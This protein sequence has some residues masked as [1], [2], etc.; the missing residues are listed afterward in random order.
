MD[1]HGIITK[2]KDEILCVDFVSP[3]P[4]GSW[5]LR[6][7]LVS[8]D[9]FTNV[10]RLYPLARPT[11]RAAL[12]AIVNKYIPE[13]RATKRVIID[14]GKQFRM[15]YGLPF[16]VTILPNHSLRSFGGP[17]EIWQKVSTRNCDDYLGLNAAI[18]KIRGLST[19]RYLLMN[20]I[21]PPQ[22]YTNGVTRR[23][24]ACASTES[25]HEET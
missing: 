4:R 1:Q 22:G 10:F 24:A 2:G 20:I 16:W 23:E 21:T 9:A 25:I 13:N 19:L 18:S 17:G 6:H 14:Q 12:N 7:L 11:T 15:H 5:R 8:T 3:L